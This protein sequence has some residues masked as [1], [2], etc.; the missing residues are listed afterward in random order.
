MEWVCL[1][2]DRGTV[3]GREPRDLY[4]SALAVHL[5]GARFVIEMTPAWCTRAADRG[6]VVEGPVGLAWLGR[7]RLFRYEVHRWKNGVIADVAEAVDSP[8]R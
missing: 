3:Q 8:Q 5:D 6:V 7:S 4:H 1:R 2:G